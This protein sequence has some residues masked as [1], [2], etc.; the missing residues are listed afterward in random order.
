MSLDSFANFLRA[1]LTAPQEVTYEDAV[2][3]EC[4]QSPHVCTEC[5][6][7]TKPAKW[8]NFDRAALKRQVK[9]LRME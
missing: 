2:F 9:V 7:G 3:Y 6:F 1:L 5:F 8:S 4:T